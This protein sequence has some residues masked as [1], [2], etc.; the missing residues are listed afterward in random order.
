MPVGRNPLDRQ[1]RATYL[2]RCQL[3]PFDPF[4]PGEFRSFR[5]GRCL[6]RP[7]VPT[8]K[9]YRRK[10]RFH[11][12]LAEAGEVVLT[13]CFYPHV[14]IGIRRSP[15]LDPRVSR[16]MVNFQQVLMGLNWWIRAAVFL[17]D[18]RII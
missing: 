18:K 6:M 10:R 14:K 7:G 15:L 3:R 4:Q 5:T 1:E 13:V 9:V 17:K 11:S 16:Y 8:G 12:V 2:Y